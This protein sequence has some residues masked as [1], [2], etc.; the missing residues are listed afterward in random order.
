MPSDYARIVVDA[1]SPSVG[2]LNLQPMA[3]LSQNADLHGVIRRVARPTQV[4]YR[5][6]ICV[7]IYERTATNGIGIKIAGGSKRWNDGIAVIGAER[8][9]TSARTDIA[10]R[11]RESSEFALHIEIPLHHVITGRVVFNEAIFQGRSFPRLHSR[12]FDEWQCAVWE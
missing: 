6:H 12:H 5:S 9:V 7:C 11:R 1:L 4:P 10:K 3:Q 8:L 2:S